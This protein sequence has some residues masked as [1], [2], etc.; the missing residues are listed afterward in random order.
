M[1]E[2]EQYIQQTVD[3]LQVVPNGPSPEQGFK[4]SLAH[5]SVEMLRVPPPGISY[6][7]N[8]M[9]SPCGSDGGRG[10]YYLG[11]R[12]HAD[13]G[14]P[15][16]PSD[17]PS[18]KEEYQAEEYQALVA[19]A[20]G[21][22][23]RMV[24][25]F[26]ME[27]EGLRVEEAQALALLNTPNHEGFGVVMA[28]KANKEDGLRP[29]AA[30]LPVLS[31]DKKRV[32]GARYEVVYV[33]FQDFQP[34]DLVVT[35]AALRCDQHWQI[36]P[37]TGFPDKCDRKTDDGHD[38]KRVPGHSE[39]IGD[40]SVAEYGLP[41]K[42]HMLTK[43]P[44][45]LRKWIEEDPERR[46][47]ILIST[48]PFSCCFEALQPILMGIQG[49]MKTESIPKRIAILGDGPNAALLA[50]T[51]TTVFPKAEIYVT[52]HTRRKVNAIEA[53]NPK[54]IHGVYVDKEGGRHAHSEIR[55]RLDGRK[56]DV[57]IP[58][59]H[60]GSLKNY[61]ELVK[62]KGR[63]IVWN[64]DQ[65][66]KE[67]PFEGVGDPDKI[68]HS[69]GGWNQAEWTALEFMKTLSQLHPK[70]LEAVLNYP[71]FYMSMEGGAAAMQQWIDRR[72]SYPVE[73]DRS[74]SGKIIIDHGNRGVLFSH[75]GSSQAL[76]TQQ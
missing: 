9:S 63:V 53:I 45:E 30:F 37:K 18:D 4:V 60:V 46:L 50:L 62:K 52:G 31:G 51:S 15:V 58:T 28:T 57:L 3:H 43:V 11:G 70:R 56:L 20:E 55:E 8:L 25:T 5:T 49:E 27:E 35:N 24:N 39:M 73:M 75:T 19:A 23:K 65:V 1:V 72:G 64:A 44:V 36:N 71:Y 14:H 47:P 54:K 66:G 17:T 13:L 6:V 61:R 69:Y 40:S 32:I 10:G 12:A 59:F 16:F 48:E 76:A 67:D 7:Q 34:G 68:H 42:S 21:M 41:Y 26:I 29:V 2:S 33:D 74:T 38:R 22:V